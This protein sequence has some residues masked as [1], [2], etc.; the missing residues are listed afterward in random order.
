M[1][2]TVTEANAVNTVL[3]ALASTADEIDGN[4]AAALEILA[5]SAHARL[6][7]GWTVA[8]VN[9]QWPDLAPA[10]TA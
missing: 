6:M 10:V 7:A 8:R 2:L 5:H 4:L 9:E 1:A 3:D